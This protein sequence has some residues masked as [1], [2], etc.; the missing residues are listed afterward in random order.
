ML[1]PQDKL[2]DATSISN[3]YPLTK[4]IGAVMCGLPGTYHLLCHAQLPCTC[5]PADHTCCPLS[6]ASLAPSHTADARAAVLKAR[7][8]AS[9][10]EFDNGYE[11]SADYLAKLV[12]DKHQVF[13]QHAS[14]RSLATYMILGGVDPECGPSLHRVDPAGHVLGY[15][16]C[17]AGVKEA[18]AMNWLEKK[19]TGDELPSQEDA[20][21]LAIDCLQTVLSTDLKAT[22]LEVAVITESNPYVCASAWRFLRPT[23]HWLTRLHVHNRSLCFGYALQHASNL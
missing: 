20:I 9:T 16:A 22:D 2:L 23:P 12:A 6:P 14:K 7:E 5:I 1:S 4:H 8:L 21:S 17:A 18:E 19:Y 3:L 15:K 10:F 11:V 13:T